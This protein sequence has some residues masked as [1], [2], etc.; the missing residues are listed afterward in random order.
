MEN[1][2]LIRKNLT[3]FMKIALNEAKKAYKKEEVPIGAIII[4]EDGKI[5][6]KAHNQVECK[7]NPLLHAEILAIQKACKKTKQKYLMNCSIFVTLEPCP[8]CATAISLAKIKNVYFSSYDEKG[9]AIINNIQ[10]YKNSKNLFKPE[11]FSGILENESSNLL[12]SFFKNLRI[13]YKKGLKR[14]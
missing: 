13:I 2:D 3:K 1:K 7:K 4:T 9:G 10:I 6:S 8:M 5:I 11:I 14:K 12:K